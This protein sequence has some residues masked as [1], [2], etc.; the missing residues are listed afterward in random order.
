MWEIVVGFSGF[1]D[2]LF[3]ADVVLC[4]S[5]SSDVVVQL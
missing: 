1:D 3:A 4:C 2:V 5:C